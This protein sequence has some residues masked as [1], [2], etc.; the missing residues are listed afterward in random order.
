[1]AFKEF[2]TRSVLSSKHLR[3]ELIIA[4]CLIVLT[5]LVFL[6]Y[7]FPGASSFSWF[8]SRVNLPM[9]LG[10]LITILMIGF[11]IILQI[12]EP[13]IRIAQETKRIASGDLSREIRLTREDE[14][15]ELGS[16]V[17]AL[18]R[19]IRESV[20]ELNALNKKTEV[21]NDEINNRIV[22]LSNLM[23][24]SNRIAQKAALHDVLRIAVSKCFPEQEMPFGCVVLKD[25]V[26]KDYRIQYVHSPRQEELDRRGV[27]SMKIPLGIG[28]LGKAILKQEALIIDQR[29]K[30]TAEI[31]DFKGLFLVRNAIISPIS[32]TGNA[33]GL[34]IA[35]NDR[36]DYVCT[37]TQKD[38]LQLVSKH[39][40]I[41][42]LNEVL[43]Q[44]IEKFEVTDPLT[45]LY[46]NA[47]ARS[48][49]GFE[50]KQAVNTQRTCSF[51]LIKVDR[52]KDYV[53][54]FGHISGE[55]ALVKIAAVLK[56]NISNQS[57][58][59]RFAEHEFAI[60][61]PGLNKREAIALAQD[62]VAKISAS[63]AKEEQSGRR[64]TVTAA[65]VENPLDGRTADELILKSG[66]ILADTIEQGGNSVGSQS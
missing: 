37:E 54:H 16:S 53:E 13:V 23:E 57:K 2:L 44:E 8:A 58:A 28:L 15:G 6:G 65:V 45:G 30:S 38:L 61:A 24:I 51:I 64:L 35:G 63:F 62:L 66:V 49:L 14:L 22:M 31:E 56:D 42:V 27:R 34:I 41:A 9:V 5:L 11:V 19:R 18:S 3:Q 39:I 12:V 55:D 47:Y 17:N 40:A 59:A 52:F 60:V 21:L 25:P 4:F 29:A 7:L 32:T 50:V 33:Y 10:I 46:N 1:M 43:S 48:R 36:P 26:T 20:E